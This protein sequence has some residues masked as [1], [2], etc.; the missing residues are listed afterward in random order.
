MLPHPLTNFEIK[1]YY[2]NEPKFNG[3]SSRNNLP[4]IKR[5]VDIINRDQY[6]SIGTHWIIFYMNAENLTHFDSYRVAHFQKKFIENKRYNEY[7]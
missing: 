7:L 4:K 5:A 3:I 2:Q 6:Q 1:R